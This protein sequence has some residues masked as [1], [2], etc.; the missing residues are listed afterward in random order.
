VLDTLLIDESSTPAGGDTTAG[1]LVTEDEL[2]F[3][4]DT[5]STD[6]LVLVIIGWT[7]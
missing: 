7:A 2:G 6:G 3:G 5:F 4:G 1:I